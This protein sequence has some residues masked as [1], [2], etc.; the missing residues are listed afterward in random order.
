M[1]SKMTDDNTCTRMQNERR[2]FVKNVKIVFRYYYYY[3]E[4]VISIKNK[5]LTL[6]SN[7]QIDLLTLQ[8]AL[9]AQTI[10]KDVLRN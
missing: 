8:T 7:K 9:F 3:Y 10:I 6:H 1:R 4:I 2:I 5:H